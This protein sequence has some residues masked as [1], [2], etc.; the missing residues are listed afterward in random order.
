MNAEQKFAFAAELID[1]VKFEILGR[2][3][4]MPEDWDGIELRRYIADKFEESVGVL[5]RGRVRSSGNSNRLRAYHNE[6][7]VRNL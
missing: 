2:I 4:D 1:S 3:D 5:A 7:L 6:V